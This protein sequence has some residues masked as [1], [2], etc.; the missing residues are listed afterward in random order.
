MPVKTPEQAAIII[1][2]L[3]QSQDLRKARL[4]K[5]NVAHIFGLRTVVRPTRI[6]RL[7]NAL[8]D[9][10][11]VLAELDTGGFGVMYAKALEGAKSLKMTMTES[12]LESP[13]YDKLFDELDLPEPESEPE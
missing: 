10:G 8:E 12:E 7:R 3:L 5:K 1:A 2:S 4:S 9:L 11:I 6:I 13:D